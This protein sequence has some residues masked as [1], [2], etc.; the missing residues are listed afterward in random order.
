M[1]ATVGSSD[2]RSGENTMTQTNARDLLITSV[3]NAHTMENQALSIM[4]P[5][6]SQIE[7]YPDIARRLEH[8]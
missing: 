5:Q 8:I 7:N 1:I 4:R 3:E 2:Q 6:L